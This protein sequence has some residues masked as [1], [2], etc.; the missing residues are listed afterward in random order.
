[1]AC[2]VAVVCYVS[3][4]G[5]QVGKEVREKERKKCGGGVTD[6]KDCGESYI[7]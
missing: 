2:Y 5:K 1:M 4:L 7:L 3:V 6:R